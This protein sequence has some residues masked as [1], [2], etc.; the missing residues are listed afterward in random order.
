MQSKEE[1]I[2]A[3]RK[4]FNNLPED[5]KEKEAIRVYNIVKDIPFVVFEDHDIGKVIK[6]LDVPSLVE[7][8]WREK[9]IRA[10]RSFVYKVLKGQHKL[11]YGYKIYYQSIE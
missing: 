9:Q 4:A 10:D 6:F 11:A 8:L 2:L 5:A 1:A 7:Y 3:F